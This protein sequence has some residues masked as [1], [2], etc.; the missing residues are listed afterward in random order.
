VIFLK[1]VVQKYGGSSLA[2]IERIKKITE[3]IVKTVK[4]GKKLIVV[5]SAMGKTTDKLVFLARR[6]SEKPNPRELDMLLSC[7]EQIS[8]ALL[9]IYLDRI[10]MKA[11]SLNAFQA[12]ILTTSDFNSARIK[13]IDDRKLRSLA[14]HNDVLLVTGFQ[15]I[16]ENDELT[17]LGRG[18]SDTSAVAIAAKLGTICEIYSDVAGIYTTDP[19]IFPQAKKL[20]YITYDEMLEFSALGARVLHSRSVEI[21][22]KYSVPIYCASS[23]SNEEGTWV[24]GKLPEWLERPVVTGAT[25]EKNQVKVSV[26][27]LKNSKATADVFRELAEKGFNVDMI[28]LVSNS[29]DINLSFTIVESNSVD[30]QKAMRDLDC[31]IK[32]TGGFSKVSIIGLGM[33][34]QRGVAAKFFEVLRK[35]NIEPEMITTSEIKISCL[36]H[37]DKAEDLLKELCQVFGL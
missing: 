7:G 13:D 8:A 4:N 36:V 24:M 31:E 28:S 1:L 37:E 10:G 14:F 32:I 21:A 30:V 3:K 6:L 23:F 25:I 5:V 35:K 2:S 27:S 34:Y 18:G 9:S 15:G 29:G 22:K 26:Y 11:V 20:S 19:R 17:T 33:K 16:N 12:R